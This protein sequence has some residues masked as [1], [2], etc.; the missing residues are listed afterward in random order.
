M[1]SKSTKRHPGF[2]E[3]WN[4]FTLS[5]GNPLMFMAGLQTK[6]AKAALESQIEM[7]D[8]LR[9]RLSKDVAFLD[10]ISQKRET[11]EVFTSVTE[12]VQEAIDDYSQETVKVV[13][14]G[15]RMA[16]DAVNH[17]E[18][19]SAELAGDFKSAGSGAG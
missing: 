16:V 2:A 5:D 6:C 15:S 19:K 18:K 1:V 17:V 10:Q 7:L 9:N 13:S 12:F 8:F 14:I 4:P 11:P 3:N